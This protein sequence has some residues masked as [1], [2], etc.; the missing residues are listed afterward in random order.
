[1]VAKLENSY[2]FV[3]RCA[4]GCFMRGRWIATSD[5]FSS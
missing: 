3:I 2:I 5:H 4:K 1:V